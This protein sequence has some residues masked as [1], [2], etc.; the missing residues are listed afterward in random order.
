MK[1]GYVRCST[2]DQNPAR[3]EAILRESGCER[4]YTDMLSGKNTER[5]G[6]QEMLNFVREG[7]TVYVESI[8]RL[9]RSTKDFLQ[10]IDQLKDKKVQFISQKEQIDTSSPQGK[11][12]LVVFAA[13][14][15]MERE[16]IRQRQK[17][18]IAIAKTKGKYRGRQPIRYDILL[19]EDLLNRWERGE[20]TQTYMCSRLGLSRS[21][22]TRRIREYKKNTKK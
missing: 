11:F 9:A 3:Q 14:A 17:E 10:I 6:L 18:G 5:P 12:M 22:L 15:E 13:L 7:D 4:V 19:F 21:T 8:S 20:I 16:T 1:I 2:H